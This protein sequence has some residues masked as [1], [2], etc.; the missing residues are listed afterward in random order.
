MDYKNI[1][2]IPQVLNKYQVKAQTLADHRNTT[3]KALYLDKGQAIPIHQF[4]LDVTFIV[5]EGH[6]EIMI[7]GEIQKLKPMDV[8]LCPPNT[9]MSVQA[10]QTSSLYFLNIKTPGLSTLK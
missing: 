1:K 3:I 5:L 2:D 8:V 7:G 9:K 4:P 6:G 10:D